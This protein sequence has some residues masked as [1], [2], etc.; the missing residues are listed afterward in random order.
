MTVS[1]KAKS[2]AVK[3]KRR[4]KIETQK[5]KLDGRPRRRRSSRLHSSMMTMLILGRVLVDLKPKPML[6]SNLVTI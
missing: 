4:R 3:R 1:L 2:M 5:R 6:L